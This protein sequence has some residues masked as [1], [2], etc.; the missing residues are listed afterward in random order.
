MRHAM[1]ITLTP[2]DRTTLEAWS[3]SRTLPVRQVERARLLL[4]AAD[5]HADQDIATLIGCSRQRC[6]R[7]RR[8]YRH[9][10][11]PAIAK[12]A[13][14]SGRP[15]T[16]DHPQIVRLTLQ[17]QPSNA[18]NWST[19]L[20]ARHHDASASTVG[21]VW[22]AH[23]IKPHVTRGFK[24]SRD[25]QFV[26]K[27][28][29][30]VGLYLAPPEHAVVLCCDE[31]SQ[32]QALERT[33]PGLPLRQGR[34]R[35]Q[36]HD[37]KRHGTTTLFAALSVLEGKVI[38]RCAPRH[39][40]GQWLKFLQTVD[41]QTLTEKSLHLVLDNY[42]THKHPRVLA[43]VARRN[44]QQQRLHGRDRI[45]LHFTP[46]SASW[47]N[48]VERFFR[49]LTVR[50]LRRGVFRSVEELVAAIED[51]LRTHNLAP[52][53]FIWTA[54]AGDILAKVTRA[55]AALDKLQKQ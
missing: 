45:V 29:D 19:R 8:R 4:R 2:T 44:R 52:K 1:K 54:K 30:I 38:G 46:T 42:G 22:R 21:R 14:R 13:P 18:T 23:G 17:T 7:T 53:P 26:E 49:D 35:T 34:C 47:L 33:Q 31:K 40:H 43:W 51:Y 28:E 50:R 32:I 10:G 27:L 36:T 37:Y 48:M 41:A 5:G 6:A 11:L 55:K 3:R 15:R 24:L 16:H 12:D 20:L 9:G 25:P 39:R